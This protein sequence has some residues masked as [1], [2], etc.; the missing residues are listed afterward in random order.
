MI[1]IIDCQSYELWSDEPFFGKCQHVNTVSQ[2]KFA[3]C[4]WFL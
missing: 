4:I 2:T 3:V 1:R